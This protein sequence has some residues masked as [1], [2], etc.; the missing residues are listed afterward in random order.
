MRVPNDSRY[1]ILAQPTTAHYLN[2]VSP[3]PKYFTTP[4][5]SLRQTLDHIRLIPHQSQQP[6]NLLPTRPN[7]SQHIT[8]F[9]LFKYQHQFINTINL[10]LDRLNKRSKRIG[11]IINKRVGD[12]IGS[13][14]YIVF[15][16]FNS[17]SNVLGMGSS[18]EMELSLVVLK[19]KLTDKVP[20]RKTMMYMLSG[21]RYV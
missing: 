16:M 6:H 18:S 13:N 5:T 1:Q 4:R 7:P 2:P 21:S 8:L 15:E 3:S 9:R 12:P 19:G 17:P 11:N 14:G 10:V 20:S